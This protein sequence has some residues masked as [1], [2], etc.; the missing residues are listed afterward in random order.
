MS[1]G[2]AVPQEFWSTLERIGA[3]ERQSGRMRQNHLG[4]LREDPTED[5]RLLMDNFTGEEGAR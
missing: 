2:G 1:E 5:M 4:V 3:Q